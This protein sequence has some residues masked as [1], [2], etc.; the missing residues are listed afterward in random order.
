[1]EVEKVEVEDL[2]Q[3]LVNDDHA[4]DGQPKPYI[5][6]KPIW[7]MKT[8]FGQLMFRYICHNIEQN[9]LVYLKD[10]WHT[11]FPGIKKEGDI[12]HDLREAKELC[13]VIWDAMIAHMDAYDKAKI[14]HQDVSTGNIL[15]APDQSG[16]LIDWDLSKKVDV[17]LPRQQSRMDF[18][19]TLPLDP[20][21][22]PDDLESFYWVLLYMVM[23]YRHPN[24]EVISQDMQDIQS[25]AKLQEEK[26]P[27]EKTLEAHKKL[28]S[29]KW[30]L[31]LIEGRLKSDPWI[32]DGGSQYKSFL[33]HDPM[34]SSCKLQG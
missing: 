34:R 24:F 10:Y 1:M 12:Y 5:T 2:H 26:E 3:I 17:D 7:E 16:L 13:Q 15:I 4:T 18:Y 22:F 23:K 32:N 9:E 28:S 19:Y 25:R 31:T 29:S 27:D 11:D 20:M 8:L 21:D 6:W 30:V 33:S 14:L